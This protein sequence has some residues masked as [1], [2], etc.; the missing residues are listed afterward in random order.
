MDDTTLKAPSQ[1]FAR[2]SQIVRGFG[3]GVL[4]LSALLF[5]L[6]ALVYWLT[7]EDPALLRQL[8]SETLKVVLVGVFGMAISAGALAFL[9]L[10]L[11]RTTSRGGFALA[12][13]LA[14]V[15]LAQLAA[16]L[17]QVET[18]VLV[19]TMV[20]GIGNAVLMLLVRHFGRIRG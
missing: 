13:L 20:V 16:L 18:T 12:G 8:L 15:L 5:A 2:I 10:W 6:A 9:G 1:P 19:H 11:S 3:L 14:G 17:W 4:V 7:E